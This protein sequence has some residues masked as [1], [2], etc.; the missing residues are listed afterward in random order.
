M[1]RLGGLALAALVLVEGLAP[2]PAGVAAG[3]AEAARFSAD[4]RLLRPEGY[5]EWVLAGASL[6]LGYS[7]PRGD[8][9]VGLFHNVYIDRGAFARY[10][11]DGTFPEGSVLVM[12]LFRPGEKAHT[13][14]SGYF[15]SERVGLEAAVKDASR[16]AGGW[17]YF[18][19][20]DG[21]EKLA[22]AF[23]ARSCADCHQAHAAT[24]NVFTQFYPTLR[25]ASR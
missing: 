13:A 3:A 21:S 22:R 6:G 12:E 17:G 23:A 18:S 4:G 5:R 14:L 25:S 20:G 8:A 19:F 10:Q 1:T 11:K 9:G 16:F 24:D 7:E 2:A 15:E